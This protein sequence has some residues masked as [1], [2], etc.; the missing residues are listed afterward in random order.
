[1]NVATH[2]NNIK[3]A[4]GWKVFWKGAG[5]ALVGAAA[6]GVG[7]AVGIGAVV[8]FGS[9]VGVTAASFTSATTGFLGGATFGGANG[10]AS[11][12]ILDTANALLERDN[13]GKALNDTLYTKIQDILREYK[14]V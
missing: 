12:F 2:W 8:G 5:Y 11:G 10:A 1:M 9:M 4:G 14:H 7:A 6:G 13:L 3:S